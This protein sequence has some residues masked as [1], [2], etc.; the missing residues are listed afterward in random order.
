MLQKIGSTISAM[1][2]RLQ[3][4]EDNSTNKSK[5]QI[6]E[7]LSLVYNGQKDKEDVKEQVDE[8]NQRLEYLETELREMKNVQK[9]NQKQIDEQQKQIDQQKKQIDEHHKQIDKQQ[10]YIDEKQNNE[11]L[12]VPKTKKKTST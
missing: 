1:Q 5:S 8:I 7:D 4:L 3:A 6:D 12:Q 9:Q 2:I 10:K 11:Q